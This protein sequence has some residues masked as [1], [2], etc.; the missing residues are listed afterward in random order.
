M[1]RHLCHILLFLACGISTA[2]AQSLEDARKN[3]T[4]PMDIQASLNLLVR[5]LET[6]ADP[7]IRERL[8]KGMLQ[9]LDGR[10]NVPPPDGWTALSQVLDTSDS[11]SVRKLTGQLRQIF[12]D[13]DATQLALATLTRRSAP[14]PARRT[15]LASLVTQRRPELAAIL[16]ELLRQESIRL[17]AIRALSAIEVR[18]APALLLGLYPEASA[19]HQ[20]AIIETL[21]TRR[22]YAEA[23]FA[24]MQDGRV[25]RNAVPAYVSRSLA[26]ML[27]ER[28]TTAYGSGTLTGG[29]EAQMARYKKLLTPAALAKAD[30][31]RGRTVYQRTCQVCHLMFGEG[32]KV[33]PDLTGSNRADL[34]YILLNIL[35]PSGDIPD[36]Y[37]LNIVT[38]RTGQVVSGI[39][40]AE[41]AGKIVLN[42]FGQAVTVLKTDI[43]K[44]ERPEVSM[45][46][47]GLLTTLKDAE[48]LDLI[49]YLQSSHQVDLPR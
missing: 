22:D 37:R 30:A 31:S 41:D 49:K 44:R 17:E 46:P 15:A 1:C 19:D 5:A 38:T 6:Q 12:G 45:M 48:V 7:A 14:L 42:V 40:V 11:E 10:R 43:A 27:G 39:I 33:G 8:L 26:T 9:G 21:S 20:R 36:A 4:Q 3:A 34:D 24:A 32:G 28:Y 47:D 35:N 25:E 13:E 23:L 2:A 16:P 29:K 18:E